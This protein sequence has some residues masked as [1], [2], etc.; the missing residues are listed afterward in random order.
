MNYFKSNKTLIWVLLVL[1][2][3]NA[4][5]MG[6]L[7]YY[8]LVDNSDLN[9]PMLPEGPPEF[10]RDRLQLDE[11]QRNEFARMHMGFRQA[12]QDIRNKMH[13]NRNEILEE[14][15]RE[16]P[17][18]GMLNQ[19]AE[20][21]GEL[22]QELK[23]ETIKHF[24]EMK[25]NIRPDQRGLYQRMIRGMREFDEMTRPGEMHGPGH[26]RRHRWGAKHNRN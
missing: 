8:H 10:L 21:Y 19:L 15:S 4:S 25:E 5:T 23:E 18:S 3:I 24:L 6:T 16:D 20:E 7:I 22:H 13:E 1:L 9:S 14:V 12:V 17:D 2:L 26:E 11:E